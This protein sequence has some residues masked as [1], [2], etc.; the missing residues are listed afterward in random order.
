MLW[1][2]TSDEVEVQCS[3]EPV[4]PLKCATG[5]VPLR[6][7]LKYLASNRQI[8]VDLVNHKMKK[9]NESKN[10]VSPESVCR[11]AVSSMAP[12][13][14][15]TNQN[16]VGLLDVEAILAHQSQKSMVKLVMRVKYVE[17]RRCIEP[18][19]FALFLTKPVRLAADTLVR[20]CPSQ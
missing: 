9:L 7:F 17:K 2:I 5:P 19:R 4:Y 18:G 13:E 3:T 20:L 11:Y 1:E 8:S 10:D 6:T 16:F 12:K 15:V 14:K